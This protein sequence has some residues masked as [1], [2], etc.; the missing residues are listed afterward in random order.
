MGNYD[1]TLAFSR[2]QALPAATATKSDVILDM[3]KTPNSRVGFAEQC[4]V[5]PSVKTTT[6]K[7]DVLTSDVQAGGVLTSPVTL[8]TV[9][10]AAGDV[11]FG[12]KLPANRKQYVQLQYTAGTAMN[13]TAGLSD[14]IESR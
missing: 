3:G 4:F 13:I 10:Y 1:V 8:M 2:G 9:N 5:I 11:N 14:T 12:F 7:V 6:L